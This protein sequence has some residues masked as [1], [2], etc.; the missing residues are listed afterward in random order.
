M[1]FQCVNSIRVTCFGINI[2]VQ[3][4][5]TGN[6]MELQEKFMLTL[7]L[8]L[9][10][11]S[12][13]SPT[14]YL[15]V[16]QTP[17]QTLSAFRTVIPLIVHLAYTMAVPCNST[18]VCSLQSFVVLSTVISHIVV[19]VGIFSTNSFHIKSPQTNFTTSL[20]ASN[21]T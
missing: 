11:I 6:D 4:N 12:I 17:S 13:L 14:L 8:S 7:I 3:L 15:V 18:F 5:T 16:T 2:W 19:I 20:A 9:T 10:P 21:H 1:A